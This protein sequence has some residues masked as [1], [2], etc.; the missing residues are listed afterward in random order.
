MSMWICIEII[1]PKY[2]IVKRT[3]FTR[4]LYVVSMIYVEVM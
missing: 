4:M 1:M 3:V 2:K